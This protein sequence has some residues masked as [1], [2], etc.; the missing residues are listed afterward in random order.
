MKTLFWKTVAG[1][2]RMA[3][4]A[5][6]IALPSSLCLP[7]RG[8]DYSINWHKIAGGGGASTGGSYAVSGTI[9]QPDAGAA[10]TGGGYALTGGFWS[11]IS[12]VQTAGPPNLMVACSANNA[13]IS[14]PNTRAYT[15][16]QSNDPSNPFTGSWVSVTNGTPFVGMQLAATNTRAF[17]RLAL[18]N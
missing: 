16:E 11:L 10:L 8:Q 9:G 1:R 7:A 3:L 17:Y 2:W 18:P 13:I 12:G 4:L 14:W 6:I 5:V 15:L